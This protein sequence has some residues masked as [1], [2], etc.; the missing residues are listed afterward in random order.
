[1]TDKI[2]K[3]T[4]WFALLNQ[5]NLLCS[6]YN[7]KVKKANSKLQ[8]M[9][10]CLDSNGSSF[11]AEMSSKGYGLSYEFICG[12]FGNYINGKYV[13]EFRNKN[14]GYYTSKLFCNY[15]DSTIIADTTILTILGCVNTIIEVSENNFV[16]IH[17]DKNSDVKIHL[18]AGSKA[19]VEYW[20]GAKVEVLGNYERVKL[21]E[22]G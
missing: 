12:C 21:T 5:N 17:V 9:N 16:R 11:M 22:N 1:M 19:N 20:K 8:L 14:G 15:S 18:N 4:D 13:G 6:E 10:C 2:E 7:N 3:I